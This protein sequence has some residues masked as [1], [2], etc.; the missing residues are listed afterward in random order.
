[1]T[2]GAAPPIFSAVRTSLSKTQDISF[3]FDDLQSERR[4]SVTSDLASVGVGGSDTVRFRMYNNYPHYIER[5]EIRIFSASDSVRSDPIATATVDDRGVAEWQ[6]STTEKLESLKVSSPMAPLKF[7][8]RVYGEDGRFDETAPQSLWLTPE[9]GDPADSTRSVSNQDD[10]ALLAGYGESEP[11]AQNISI[12]TNGA[13]RIDGEGVPPNHSVWLAGTEI[14]VDAEGNFVGEVLLPAGL[15]TVE[16]AV[17]DEEGNGELFLRDLELEQNDWFL[18]GIADLTLAQDIGGSTPDELQGDNSIDTDAFAN[19]RL[20]FFTNGK[21]GEDWKLTASADTREGPVDELFTN[22]LDKSPDSLFRR[23]D[24]D[25]HYPT[26]GDDSTIDEMA[27][28]LGKFYVKLSKDDDHLLWGNFTVRY[29][30]NELALV[31]RGLYGANARYQSQAT[32]T[33]GERRIVIDGFAADPG[34]VTS[35]EDFRGTGGSVYFLRR[36]D[37]LI[38]SERLR[39]EIRDKA[40]GLVSEV[41]E[42]QPELD[43]DIDYLQG[44]VLLSEPISAIADDKLL[45][46]NDGLSGNEV[47]LVVQYEYTPG[48]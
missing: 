32:T 9:Q 13:V 25:Y 2:R 20:A 46:R 36:Q 28:T 11:I 38:G 19:G 27:P 17:L 24:P 18:V 16:V 45:V 37:L 15:H 22:F 1:M 42:L 40:S 43:Y 34:T 30:A 10:S 26:F 6:P 8:V 48:L 12:G 23:L 5:A 4:L 3:R 33:F 41:V 7:L 31:E 35:R 14:P 44:R 21:F 47:Y 39:I 29:N